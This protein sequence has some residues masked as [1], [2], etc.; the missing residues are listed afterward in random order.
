M[1]GSVV[2]FFCFHLG[3]FNGGVLEEKERNKKIK[4]I[5]KKM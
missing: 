4:G 5:L 1:I 2:L 3:G